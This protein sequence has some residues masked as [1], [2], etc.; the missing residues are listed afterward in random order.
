MRA[1]WKFE[2]ENFLGIKDI[3]YC[4]GSSA[5]LAICNSNFE[6]PIKSHRC[7]GMASYHEVINSPQLQVL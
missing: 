3:V 7:L 4:Y 1:W 6:Y 2:V 5:E